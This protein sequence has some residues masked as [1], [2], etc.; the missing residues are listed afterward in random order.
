MTPSSPF[1][2]SCTR[3]QLSRRRPAGVPGLGR[4]APGQALFALIALVVVIGAF[5]A[6]YGAL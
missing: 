6:G 4:V 5:L 1:I 3:S 2:S